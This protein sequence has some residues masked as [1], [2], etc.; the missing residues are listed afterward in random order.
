M[1]AQEVRH[2]VGVYRGATVEDNKYMR[3]NKVSEFLDKWI[4]ALLAARPTTDAAR[5]EF[6]QKYL[7]EVPEA[8]PAA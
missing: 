6:P 8:S 7:K 3:A 5:L 4:L 1:A 2:A